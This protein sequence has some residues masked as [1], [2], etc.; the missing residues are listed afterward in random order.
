[1]TSA[2][3]PLSV[4]T[5]CHVSRSQT[6]LNPH[7]DALVSD[8]LVS[9]ALVSDALVSDALVS[10]ELVSVVFYPLINCPEESS[11]VTYGYTNT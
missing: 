7:Y 8:A 1:M 3:C 2:E 4:R 9:D 10:D 5:Q 11:S 6:F